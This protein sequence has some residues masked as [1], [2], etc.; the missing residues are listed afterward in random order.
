MKIAT[1]ISRGFGQWRARR[2]TEAELYGLD[3]RELRDLGISRQDIP[4][5]ARSS[6]Y[7]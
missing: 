2:R 4:E 6:V 1:K 3:D 5:V 7:G